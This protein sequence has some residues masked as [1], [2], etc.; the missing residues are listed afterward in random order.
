MSDANQISNAIPTKEHSETDSSV[1]AKSTTSTHFCDPFATVVFRTSDNV[2]FRVHDY[3]LKAASE[4]FRDMLDRSVQSSSLE[5]PISVDEASNDFEIMLLIITGR[6]H[7][8]LGRAPQTWE[9]AEKLY[10][11]VDKYQLD[12]HQLWFSELCAKEAGKQ[13]IQALILACD[14]PCVDTTLARCAIAEGIPGL[15][16]NDPTITT[17]NFVQPSGA[18]D[19]FHR[20]GNH[21]K[22]HVL[23]PNNMT[24]DFRLRL[25]FKG[26]VAYTH[27]FQGSSQSS[28]IDWNAMANK[29]VANVRSIEEKLGGSA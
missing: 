26:L 2:I 15:S 16:A 3:F 11:L 25:G 23:E 1:A 10:R 12:G 22:Y 8:V 19:G 20:M 21:M 13:P 18:S 28:T 24:L 5:N 4:F 27:T 7:A 6:P 17:V 29:F 9:H 14:R